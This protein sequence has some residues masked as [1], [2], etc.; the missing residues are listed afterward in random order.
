MPTRLRR[1]AWIAGWI[2]VSMAM[3]GSTTTLPVDA[4]PA[5][6][7]SVIVSITPQRILDTRDPTDLGLKGPFVSP[8][9]QRLRVTG[10]VATPSGTQT[11]V[12]G[13]ATGVLLNVTSVGAEA[14]GFISVRPGDARG[15]PT[16]SSLNF[17]AGT[18]IPNAVHVALPTTGGDAGRIDIT[19]DA[20]GVPGPVTD[21]LVDVVGYT[22][23]SGL[24]DLRAQLA[25]KAD[26]TDVYSRSMIDDRLS[27]KAN[28]TEVY[29]SRRWTCEPPT[30]TACS[31]SSV[32]STPRSHRTGTSRRR[33]RRPGPP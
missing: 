14:A 6:Q 29:T 21:V 2:V 30:P 15:A 33:G 24:D 5:P 12:P 9:S 10:L 22:E 23:A 7:H 18:T 8:V 11:V 20:L 16:T 13:G 26:T 32:R 25:G 31:R 19:Y 3:L 1:S 27:S 28:T 4:Q 17:D